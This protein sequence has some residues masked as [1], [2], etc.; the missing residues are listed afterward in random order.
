MWLFLEG[1][2]WLYVVWTMNISEGSQQSTK[3]FGVHESIS[4]QLNLED[5]EKSTT[6]S[7]TDSE[8]AESRLHALEGS[9]LKLSGES[10]LEMDKS[11]LVCLFRPQ[12]IISCAIDFLLLLHTML[13][14]RWKKASGPRLVIWKS[15]SST[16]LDSPWAFRQFSVK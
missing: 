14:W 16:T 12:K 5:A 8:G 13:K 11:G 3:K 10:V 2:R 4:Q 6:Q 9:S 15:I 1:K 7:P